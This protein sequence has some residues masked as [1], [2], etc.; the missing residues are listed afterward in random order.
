MLELRD[1]SKSFEAV[2]ALR[3]ISLKLERGQIGVLIG[4]SGSGKSSV[5]R[6]LIGLLEPDAGEVYFAGE[7]IEPARVLALRRR[8]GYVIQDGG[9]FAHLS[10]YDNI[11]L[12]PRHVR[13]PNERL[14][15]RIEE[16]R[17]LVRLS[18]EVLRR[19]PAQ[20]SGGE[21][22]RVSLMRA[23]VLDP[24]ALLLDEPLAALD[25]ITRV[26][27]QRDLRSIFRALQKTVLFVTH[28]LRE[29]EFFGD[30]VALMRDGV[31]VQHGSYR[32]LVERPADEFVRRFVAA[33]C[34]PIEQIEQI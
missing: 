20:L 34:G 28:D 11:A 14:H 6:L 25:P 2:A 27:L 9:L 13:W 31:I 7:R 17:R 8:M 29:A 22:Q 30:W 16:L 23:L 5:L 32:D 10:A 4:V 24:D 1:V 3:G 33:Q 15:A 18:A 21:R 12:M 26:E 19:Y